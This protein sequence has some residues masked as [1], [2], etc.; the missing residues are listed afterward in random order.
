[1]SLTWFWSWNQSALDAS[2]DSAALP[3]SKSFIELQW[4]YHNTHWFQL[5]NSMIFIKFTKLLQSPHDSPILL[6][7]SHH[8]KQSPPAHLQSLSVPI[9]NHECMFCLY[10]FAPPRHLNI[11]SCS[12]WSAS[13]SLG[14]MWKNLFYFIFLYVGALELADVSSELPGLKWMPGLTQWKVIFLWGPCSTE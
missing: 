5:Y 11:E 14:I 1:M 10:N 6:V 12:M 3:W 13:H 4:T 7:H 8:P 9:K 2:W